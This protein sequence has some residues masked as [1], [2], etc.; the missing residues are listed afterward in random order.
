VAGIAAIIKVTGAMRA[1]I[2]PATLGATD[3]IPEFESSPIRPLLNAEPWPDLAPRR[4]GISNFG[5]G[6]N[7]A[8]LVLEAHQPTGRLHAVSAPPGDETDDAPWHVQDQEI[9]ICGVG[10]VRGD[11][12]GLDALGAAAEPTDAAPV[13]TAVDLPLK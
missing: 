5:F 4:A 8:H 13:T 1:G 7:N 3:P 6:G 11:R 2:R 9:V 10:V 12:R